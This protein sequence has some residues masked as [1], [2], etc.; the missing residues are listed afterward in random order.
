MCEGN[1]REALSLCEWHIRRNLAAF[2]SD[3]LTAIHNSPNKMMYDSVRILGLIISSE[4]NRN[5][6]KLSANQD[7]AEMR[8]AVIKNVLCLCHNSM[9]LKTTDKHLTAN[10]NHLSYTRASFTDVLT[11]TGLDT[12]FAY[13]LQY[14]A[15]L[16]TQV[17]PAPPIVRE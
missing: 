13:A 14:I 11:Q 2:Q 9:L 7:S 1:L 16:K 4:I 10:L 12:D 5:L 3:Q 15:D 8:H 17:Y 6:I